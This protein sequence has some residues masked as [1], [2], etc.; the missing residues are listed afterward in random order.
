MTFGRSGS[1]AATKVDPTQSDKRFANDFELAFD[2]GSKH[3][4]V[5]VIVIAPARGEAS[6][7]LCCAPRVPQESSGLARYHGDGEKGAPLGLDPATQVGVLEARIG[8]QVDLSTK[9]LLQLFKQ[10][11]IRFSLGLGLELDEKIEIAVRGIKAAG[12]GRAEAVEAVHPEPPAQL[13]DRRQV[14]LNNFGVPVFGCSTFAHRHKVI[15]T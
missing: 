9:K 8:K 14:S 15:T 10:P 13:G 5:H 11:E 12:R 1:C 3:V 7:A 2:C 6:D 4:V